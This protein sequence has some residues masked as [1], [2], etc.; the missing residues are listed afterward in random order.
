LC[1]CQQS[2]KLKCTTYSDTLKEIRDQVPEPSHSE[3]EIKDVYG[4]LLD[5]LNAKYERLLSLFQQLL[6]STK[7]SNADREVSHLEISVMAHYNP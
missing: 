3:P 1:L 2:F 5:D 6:D 7:D 4:S